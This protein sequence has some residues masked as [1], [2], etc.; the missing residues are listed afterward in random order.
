MAKPKLVAERR[1]APN[2]LSLRTRDMIAQA[3]NSL[4]REVLEV[5]VRAATPFE[6]WR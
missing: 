2:H 1:A 3:A 4:M 6:F 5:A